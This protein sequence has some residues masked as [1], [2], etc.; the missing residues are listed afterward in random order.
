MDCGIDG[1]MDF[2]QDVPIGIISGIGNLEALY[3]F[4][5]G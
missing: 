4:E 5:C 1:E 3:H 2:E